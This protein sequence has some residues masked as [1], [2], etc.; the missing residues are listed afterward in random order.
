MAARAVAACA[1]AAVHRYDARVRDRAGL[2]EDRAAGSAAAAGLVAVRAAAA[3]R[4]QDAG[5]RDRDRGG[6]RDLEDPA[7]AAAAAAV[8]VVRAA[9][10][11][12]AA[13]EHRARSVVDHAAAR[14]ARDVAF[15]AAVA[16]AGAVTAAAAAALIEVED[17]AGRAAGATHR[18]APALLRV[19]ADLA[20]GPPRAPVGADV[21]G[22]GDGHAPARQQDEA[23]V[24][25][26]LDPSS[27]ID[28][29]GREGERGETRRRGLR[30][31]DP[32]DAGCRH[33]G[34]GGSDD[35][36]R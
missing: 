21:D 24:A 2:E 15:A 12:I 29:D 32:A 4:A 36:A 5:R 35:R 9:P 16:S 23:A 18:A 19:S 10:A 6:G 30:D 22:A 31:R 17:S 14:P 26:G 1:A 25:R 20:T 33:R 27:C 34:A 3:H 11:A 13:V 28:G 8:G 7:A